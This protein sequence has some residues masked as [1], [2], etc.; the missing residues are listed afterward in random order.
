[1]FSSTYSYIL[2]ELLQPLWC[3]Y[4]GGVMG[5]SCSR[6][7]SVEDVSDHKVPGVVC[8]PGPSS[9]P[10][11]LPYS[12]LHPSAPHRPAACPTPETLAGG[13]PGRIRPHPPLPALYSIVR[14]ASNGADDILL[15]R[16]HF[17]K[18]HLHACTVL[19]QPISQEFFS[20]R[21]LKCKKAHVINEHKRLGKLMIVI[22]FQSSFLTGL[23]FVRKYLLKCQTYAGPNHCPWPAPLVQK[24]LRSWT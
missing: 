1:M 6:W 9:S 23:A 8:P 18:W 4:T 24:E 19:Y 3:K 20:W 5:V 14:H 16:R 10:P 12:W 7:S 17:A 13:G 22:I 21:V 11:S 15:G 2:I